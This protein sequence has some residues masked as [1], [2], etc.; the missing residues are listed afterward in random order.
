MPQQGNEQEAEVDTDAGRP[1]LRLP[2]LHLPVLKE[3]D[4]EEEAGQRPTDVPRVPGGYHQLLLPRVGLRSTVVVV[5]GV[6]DVKEGEGD[7]E[8]DANTLI[9]HSF[10][11]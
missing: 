4:A 7:H 1:Q 3:H 8:R 10:M 9:P 2:P 5:E 11:Q 6:A